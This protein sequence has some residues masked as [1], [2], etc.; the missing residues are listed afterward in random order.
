MHV[1]FLIYDLTCLERENAQ[2]TSRDSTKNEEQLNSHKKQIRI[3]KSKIIELSCALYLCMIREL[4][5]HYPI[6]KE[7]QTD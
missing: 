7:G 4:E 5:M 1:I 3:G 6:E 2:P